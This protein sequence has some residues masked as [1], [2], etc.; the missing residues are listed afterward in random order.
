MS[1]TYYN[2]PHGLVD[3]NNKSTASDLALLVSK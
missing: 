2:N 1:R 3:F